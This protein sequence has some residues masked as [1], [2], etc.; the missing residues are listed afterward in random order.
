MAVARGDV[1]DDDE[2]GLDDDL[3]DADE[4]VRIDDASA[5][6]VVALRR[7][8]G[9][10]V[11]FRDHRGF[12]ARRRRR[13]HVR[14]VG[15]GALTV[16]SSGTPSRP[17]G[18]ARPATPAPRA[19]P[20]AARARV[21]RA[22]VVGGRCGADGGREPPSTTSAPGT[23]RR[24][25]RAGSADAAGRCA[26]DR[27]SGRA[28][29]TRWPARREQPAP[30]AVSAA[31]SAAPPARP[32]P[33]GAGATRPAALLP[34]RRPAGP[35]RA[36]LLVTRL[37]PWSVMKTAFM[38]SIAWNH[39]P[40]SAVALLSWSLEVTGVFARSARRSTTWPRRSPSRL[41]LTRGL[42]EVVGFTARRRRDRPDVR[43]RHARAFL[44]NLSV[45]AP[46][47]HRGHARRRQ[48][49]A[50]LS[51]RRPHRVLPVHRCGKTDAAT[52]L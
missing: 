35:R 33:G 8:A 24:L 27:G 43:A 38:L 14:P 40:S 48:L 9:G 22:A 5:A 20:R 13:A 29:P 3:V 46:R 31:C 10:R 42:Q 2:E 6:Q 37:D 16:D 1:A 4:S 23:A 41:P 32:A 15:Q 39:A 21:R 50:P 19:E 49:S 34:R 12:W 7:V 28:A 18:R 30:A 25:H 47:R 52:G 26:R 11:G 45:V 36:R 51:A 44:Y 17:V